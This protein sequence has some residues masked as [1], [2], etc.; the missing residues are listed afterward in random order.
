MGNFPKVESREAFPI[1]GYVFPVFVS[2]PAFSLIK[3]PVGRTE[4]TGRDKT[5]QDRTAQ[6]RTY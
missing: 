5:G 2:V 1:Q 6:D 4:M 3:P